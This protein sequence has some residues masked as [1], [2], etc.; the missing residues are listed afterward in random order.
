MQNCDLFRVEVNERVSAVEITVDG[1][2]T[3]Y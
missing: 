2:T 1:L 3:G